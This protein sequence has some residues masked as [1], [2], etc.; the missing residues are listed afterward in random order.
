MKRPINSTVNINDV[1]NSNDL[2][3]TTKVN[4]KVKIE[5]IIKPDGVVT[6]SAP[7]YEI[8]KLLLLFSAFS[9]LVKIKCTSTTVA[10]FVE[11]KFI[12]DHI[13]TQHLAELLDPKSAFQFSNLT[14]GNKLEKNKKMSM[15]ALFEK[16]QLDD[17]THNLLENEIYETTLPVN[18]LLDSFN[19]L[20]FTT[21]SSFTIEM[22]FLNLKVTEPLIRISKKISN[23]KIYSTSFKKNTNSK[24]IVNIA[25]RKRV[26]TKSN[27]LAKSTEPAESIKLTESTKLTKSNESK[28]FDVDQQ[29]VDQQNK[30]QIEK[31]IFSTTL[32]TIDALEIISM[33]DKNTKSVTINCT[34]NLVSFSW[35]SQADNVLRN[36]EYLIKSEN[37]NVSSKANFPIEKTFDVLDLHNILRYSVLFSKNTTIHFF[38]ESKLVITNSISEIGKLVID[39]D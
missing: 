5:T 22:S 28:D 4:K 9:K 25:K 6:F 33:I 36:N 3:N 21:N 39:I 29:N 7:Y 24:T 31:F 30:I 37:N 13:N 12:T 19:F 38:E 18:N 26:S 8:K 10:F 27:K 23:E 20:N 14:N 15:F 32:K 17:Y 11:N 16:N 35:K 34:D 2:E 1:L